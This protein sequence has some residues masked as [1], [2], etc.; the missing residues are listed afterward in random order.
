MCRSLN[1]T[2][3]QA[4]RFFVMDSETQRLVH[5]LLAAPH[6]SSVL[7]GMALSEVFTFLTLT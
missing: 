1:G 7:P 3:S 2:V 6:P 5:L 4:F